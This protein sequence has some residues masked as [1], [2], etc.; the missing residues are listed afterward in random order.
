MTS[1]QVTKNSKT[2]EDKPSRRRATKEEAPVV[3]T[4]SAPVEE[5]KAKRARKPKESAPVEEAVKIVPETIEEVV[6]TVVETVVVESSE[7]KKSEGRRVVTRESVDTDFDSL[8]SQLLADS[9]ALKETG[10]DSKTVRLLRQIAKRVRQLKTDSARVSKQKT[11]TT[12]PSNTSSGFMKAVK[13]SKEMAKFTNWNHEELYTRVAVTKELCQ[14]IKENDLQ[15][16]EDRRQI[17]PDEKLAKL[18]AYDGK[19]DKPLTYYYLQQKIQ[20]HF[21]Q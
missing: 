11:R 10:K 9:D 3:V 16:P 15:N 19:K 1:K 13:I 18:L 6:E 21:V 7:E 14:Y 17:L 4:E 8:V 20:P 5:K 2:S 12:R